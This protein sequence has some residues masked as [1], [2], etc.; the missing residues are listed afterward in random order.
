MVRTRFYFTKPQAP[1]RH[2]EP[3]DSLFYGSISA[4]TTTR[5]PRD[6]INR[7]PNELLDVIF[8][9]MAQDDCGFQEYRAVLSPVS[10]RWNELMKNITSYWI[11]NERQ[12]VALTALFRSDPSRALEAKEMSVKYSWDML[13]ATNEIE[14]IQ[15]LLLTVPNLIKLYLVSHRVSIL[16]SSVALGLAPALKSLKK[17]ED[18]ELLDTALIIKL[19]FNE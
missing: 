14:I 1:Y 10:P 2:L 19:E 8:Q 5:S 4:T 11:Y 18:F 13:R 12:A 17:M 7:L 9:R 16:G 3:P 15:K 6:C